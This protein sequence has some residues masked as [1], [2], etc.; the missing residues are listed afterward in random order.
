MV[1]HTG[2]KNQSWDTCGKKKKPKQRYWVSTVHLDVHQ[3]LLSVVSERIGNVTR[4][5]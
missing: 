3:K 5:S 1:T 2:I 4:Q